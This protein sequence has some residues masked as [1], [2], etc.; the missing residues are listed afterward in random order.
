MLKEHLT[1]TRCPEQF[2]C[3]FHTYFT[4]GSRLKYFYKVC[5]H[6]WETQTGSLFSEKYGIHILH[7]QELQ[8]PVCSS[9]V[10][11]TPFW[12]N[13]R[14]VYLHVLNIIFCI[15]MLWFH[16]LFTFCILIK[17]KLAKDY[18]TIK[19]SIQSIKWNLKN[20]KFKA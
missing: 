8:L 6:Y 3:F 11:S 2:Y 7:Q 16:F 15:Y 13:D 19:N 20:S 9:R 5:L 10:C 4:S 14:Y 12:W 1:V 18:S 17:Q